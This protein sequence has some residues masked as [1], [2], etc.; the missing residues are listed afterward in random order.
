MGR[1]QTRDLREHRQHGGWR[2][3]TGTDGR[4]EFAK[5]QD[6]RHLT[7]VVGHFP[8]P[9]AGRVGG[10]E[11]G[12]HRAPQDRGIDATPVFELRQKLSRGPDDGGGERCG[13]TDGKR[14]GGAA[15]KRFGH[16][17]MSRESGNGSNREALSSDRDGS[18]PSR[19]ASPS[20]APTTKGDRRRTPVPKACA[21]AGAAC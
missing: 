19:P 8:V 7:S 13:G 5:E 14:R 11:G 16:G 6:S 4:A 20:Q 17:R 12:L 21:A 2:A 9:G 10:A 1:K 18:N 3:G 15:G